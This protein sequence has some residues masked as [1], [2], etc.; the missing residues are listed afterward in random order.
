MGTMYRI[1]VVEKRWG[2]TSYLSFTSASFAIRRLGMS[3]VSHKWKSPVWNVW[4]QGAGLVFALGDMGFHSRS[5]R[6]SVCWR[7]LGT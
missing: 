6:H 2:M 3:V 5:V 7:G 1:T 4:V